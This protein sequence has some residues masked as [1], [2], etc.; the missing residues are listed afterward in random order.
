MTNLNSLKMHLSRP[1][2]GAS[3]GGEVSEIIEGVYEG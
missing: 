1:D 2:T 3:E